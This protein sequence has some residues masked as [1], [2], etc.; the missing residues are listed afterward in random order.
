MSSNKRKKSD[1][2]S[3][4]VSRKRLTLEEK[5]DI[6]KLNE[7]GL[8]KAQIGK[9]KEMHESSPSVRKIIKDKDQIKKQG[10]LT[11]KYG[12]KCKTKTRKRPMLEM[13]SFF[14]FPN[15]SKKTNEKMK[16]FDLLLL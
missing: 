16:K 7:Q 6:I 14:R 2:S 10:A 3:V 11:A 5:L 9:Q 8:S 15:F 1:N 4:K 12:A 13:K